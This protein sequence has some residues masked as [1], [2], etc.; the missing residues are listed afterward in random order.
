MKSIGKK[1]AVL[2]LLGQ[3]D[4][5]STINAD[6]PKLGQIVPQKLSKKSQIVSYFVS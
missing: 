3:L 5:N 2:A 6:A 1:S 4:L